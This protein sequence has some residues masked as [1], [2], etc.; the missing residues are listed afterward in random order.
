MPRRSRMLRRPRAK[1]AASS[2]A[3]V[4]SLGTALI[5]AVTAVGALVISGM[6]WSTQNQQIADQQEA[7]AVGDLA[8]GDAAVR[9][10]GIW[11][12]Q[13]L[14]QAHPDRE[15]AVV[16]VLADFVRARV[17][18]TS[19]DASCPRPW[20]RPGVDVQAAM[21]VIAQRDVARDG[22]TML[23]LNHTCLERIDLG[24]WANDL[25]ANLTNVSLVGADLSWADLAWTD[26]SGS[27]L[28]DADM[29]HADLNSTTLRGTQLDNSILQDTD[30]AH[31]DAR[32]ANL[33]GAQGRPVVDPFTTVSDPGEFATLTHPSAC[34][35]YP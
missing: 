26:L 11:T 32:G 16:R 12:L 15:P 33:R 24:S 27:I 35:P 31:A 25:H 10:A 29:C 18:L 2:R 19:P 17:G 21:T 30:F 34:D 23:D 3:V 6:T 14:T 9:A 7:T 28:S 5:S 20:E 1:A 22:P 8:N 4:I 13:Q